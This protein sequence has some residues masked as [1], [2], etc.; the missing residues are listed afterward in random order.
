MYENNN[1]H[2]GY[3]NGTYYQPPQQQTYYPPYP[4]Q[5][6][7]YAQP[8]QYQQIPPQ[9]QGYAPP[10]YYAPQPQYVSPE[11]AEQMRMKQYYL[12]K[13]KEEKST[14][15]KKGF[16]IGSTLVAML[17]IEI[18]V[19]SF[20]QHSPY[21]SLYDSS[22]VFQHAFNIFAV[23]IMALLVP[24]SAMAAVL[25]NSSASPI[26]P[27]KKLSPM[28]T[29]SWVGIG[30][31]VCLV[32]NFITQGVIYLFEFFGYELTTPDSL[33][34]DSP[35]ACVV[36]VFSTIIAPGLIEEYCLRA[37][38]MS[39]LKVHGKAYAVV[40]VSI[41]FGLIHGNIIQFVFA[42]TIGLILGY[43]TIKTDSIIPAM[44]IHG[45]NNSLSVIS[46]ILE[47]TSGEKVADTVTALLVLFWIAAAV[48]GAIYLANKKELLPK[49]E[50]VKKEPYAL[51]MGEKLLCLLPGLFIPFTILII[52]T[53]QYIH[54]V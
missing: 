14:L 3:G 24:F 41:V 21:Y 50:V 31:G 27:N 25:K 9:Y 42:F 26:V 51:S 45:L 36:L 23:H 30:L 7:G 22:A 12:N 35:L 52:E 13:R 54:H 53:G 20:L 44:L 19:I 16:V 46:E 29:L 40:A 15:M 6:Q 10:V 1:Q 11:T 32:A 33:T 18:I 34:V 2:Q 28:T 4:P 39:A 43:V 38:T 17:I 47:Y 8:P 49:K 5:Q 48:A 37:C